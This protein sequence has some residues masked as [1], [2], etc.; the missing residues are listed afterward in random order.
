L[1]Q[2]GGTAAQLGLALATRIRVELAK[3]A[4]QSQLCTDPSTALPAP[5]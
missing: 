5:G 1:Q 2:L 3:R 4:A